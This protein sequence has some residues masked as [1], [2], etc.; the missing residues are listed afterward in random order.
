MPPSIAI[1]V[2]IFIVR[3]DANCL[4][5]LELAALLLVPA[6]FFWGMDRRRVLWR[7]LMRTHE[8]TLDEIVSA[9]M[10]APHDKE[11]KRDDIEKK[12]GVE[13]K[14][15]VEILKRLGGKGLGRYIVGRGGF[16]TRFEWGA[17]KF[18]EKSEQVA[19]SRWPQP[20]YIDYPYPLGNGRYGT[21]RIPEDIF[22]TEK[23]RLALIIRD[24]LLAWMEPPHLTRHAGR[25]HDGHDP[26]SGQ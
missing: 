20:A 6:F 5:A 4:S 21:L 16:D 26:V 2:I 25:R 9:I 8:M 13:K 12:Y 24:P 19:P 18:A 23:T 7:V 14:D 10:Q 22:E 15:A 17:T 1:C 3:L 11:T